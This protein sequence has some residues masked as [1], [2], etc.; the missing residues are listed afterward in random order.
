MDICQE[1]EDAKC[2]VAEYAA[3]Y[4]TASTFGNNTD[5]MFYELLLLNAYID[6][7]TRKECGSCDESCLTD[8]EKCFILNQ[9]ALKCESFK[10]GC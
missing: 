3:A 8:D 9:I 2:C 1:I 7:L 5:D 6:A 4:V 10:C